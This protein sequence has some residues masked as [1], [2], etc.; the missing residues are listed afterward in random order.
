[1]TERPDWDTYFLGVAAAV[2]I[3]ADCSRRQVGCVIV[4]EDHRIIATGYNGAPA[5][6]PGCLAGYCPRGR[7]TEE[8]AR[9]VEKNYD[10][11][12]YYCIAVH[13]EANALLHART[14]CKG[15][16]VYV[17]KEPCPACTKLLKA[18]GISRLVIA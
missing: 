8:E 9:S 5:G 1:M 10:F 17:T 4:D 18:A 2:S 13:A 16:T 14:S 7:L 6:E 15:A 12:P 3:R 11:G